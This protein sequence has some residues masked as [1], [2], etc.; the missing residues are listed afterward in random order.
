MINCGARA[1]CSGGDV[2]ST[3]ILCAFTAFNSEHDAGGSTHI[4]SW[5]IQES[6]S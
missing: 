6:R 3:H 1:A 2:Y 5:V 4:E